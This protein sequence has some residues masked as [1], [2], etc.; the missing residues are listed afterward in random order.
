MIVIFDS[1]ICSSLVTLT[2][3]LHELRT[4]RVKI[5]NKK[6]FIIKNYLEKNRGRYLPRK[7]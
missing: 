3:Q 5:D 2:A 6:V 4:V 1:K 7:I